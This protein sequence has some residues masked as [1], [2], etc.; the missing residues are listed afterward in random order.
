M[1]RKS[2]ESGFTP[3]GMGRK[4]RGPGL[5]SASAVGS[6]QAGEDR[7]DA[8]Q[9]GLTVEHDVGPAQAQHFVAH[10]PQSFLAPRVVI[11]HT[12]P[13]VD[14][15]PVALDDQPVSD[16]EVDPPGLPIGAG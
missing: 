10:G 5:L 2:R 15:A 4:S 11:P 12:E 7:S 16:Q 3:A 9:G 14:G 8:R 6:A 13:V 1:G